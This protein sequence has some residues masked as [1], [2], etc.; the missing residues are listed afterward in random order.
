[1]FP[2]NVFLRFLFDHYFISVTYVLSMFSSSFSSCRAIKAFQQLLYVSP[3][4]VRSNE[5][6]LRLG[7]MF[8]VTHEYESSLKH[9]Q[10][11]LLDSAPCTFS[12]FE[13]KFCFRCTCS[14]DRFPMNVLGFFNWTFPRFFFI[15][16]LVFSFFFLDVFSFCSTFS[17]CAPLWTTRQ[18]QNCKGIVRT[19]AW[20]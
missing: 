4:F 10:L 3:D 12:K 16:S 6:H 15:N 11:A 9:L 2:K 19:F 17:Y 5:A 13:S 18:I 14:I 1:M 8:K 20:R 7:L